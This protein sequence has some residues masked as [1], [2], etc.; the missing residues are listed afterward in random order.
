MDL[1]CSLY[2]KDY[3]HSRSR[4][5]DFQIADFHFVIVDEWNKIFDTDFPIFDE[6]YL[7]DDELITDFLIT[8]NIKLSYL[9]SRKPE[10]IN[11]IR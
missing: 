10:S 3:L 4:K 2:K 6:R 11:R 5:K 9:D 8:F 7:I 1:S